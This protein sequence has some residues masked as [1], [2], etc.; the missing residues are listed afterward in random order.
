MKHI[1]RFSNVTSLFVAATLC[2][3]L[4]TAYVLASG[5]S[6]FQQTINPGTL[7]S[8][9]VDGSYASVSS[10]SMAMSAA[11]FSF[12]CQTVTGTFGT[13]AEKIYVVN[14]DAADNGW[15]LTVAPASVAAVWDGAASDYDFNDST[16]AGCTDGADADSVGGQMTVNASGGTLAIGECASCVTTNV[17]KGSLSAFVSG[18]TDSV[19]LLNASATSDDIGD[20]AL[21]GVS[22]TQTVPA[23]QGAAADYD[24][25]MVVTATAS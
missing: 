19:T 7:S 16:G 5:T 23:E 3:A 4:P 9:I 13:S 21:T 15:T 17:S 11:T 12:S 22:I 2:V 25:N 14:P 10:P 1:L 24:I 20:W 18:T 6:N 8:D